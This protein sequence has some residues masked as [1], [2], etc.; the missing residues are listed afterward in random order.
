MDDSS[1]KTA[2]PGTLPHA[3]THA[4]PPRP[5][6]IPVSARLARF[7]TIG[8][9]LLLLGIV[10]DQARTLL[11]PIV[12]A[13]L[14]AVSRGPVVARTLQCMIAPCLFAVVIFLALRAGANAVVCEASAAL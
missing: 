8:I 7:A 13:A 10:L 5:P 3:L 14:I 2:T 6:A 11:L 12:S 4:V 9:F 1:D